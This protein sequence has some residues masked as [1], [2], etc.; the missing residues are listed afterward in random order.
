MQTFRPAVSRGLRTDSRK[1]FVEVF[2]A[3][4][5]SLERGRA[6]VRIPTS[7]TLF[8]R[9]PGMAFHFKPELFIQIEGETEFTCPED[10]FV[11]GPGQ[12][13]IMPKGVPHGEVARATERPFRNMV[14][15]Y[16]N[17]TVAVHVAEENP[18]G[19][20]AVQDI[21][22]FATELFHD[23]VEYLNRIGQLRFSE[24]PACATAIKGLLLAELA[25]LLALVED[26]EDVRY[27]ETERVF[28][29]QW[30]IRNNL[31]DPELG[32]NSL[33]SELNCSPSHLS[34]LFHRETGERI[35]EYVTRVRLA[36]ALDALSHTLLSV[37]EI[38]VACGFNDPN[39]FTRVFRKATGVSP[40]LFRE[41][42]HRVACAL[43]REPKAVF[44]D[45][46]EHGFALRPEVLARARVQSA[47]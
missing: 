46:E 16:Y 43:E 17:D 7:R 42:R 14:V 41:Q 24:R 45:H 15:C 21:H 25:L 37:K 11:L 30:L 36:N 29:C 12:I 10:R 9:I 26:S 39:Y 27:T 20:P 19:R 38:A 4:V 5:R 40:A 6:V 2:R 13:C 47:L 23:L 44:E 33:A 3:C 8:Q 18:P 31:Q 1:L 34:K 32:V 35:V 28:R 22:F